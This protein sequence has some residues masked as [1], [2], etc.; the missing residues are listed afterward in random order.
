MTGSKSDPG[1]KKKKKR[2]GH[3]LY[4][5][6]VK[7]GCPV[8]TALHLTVSSLQ[9]APLTRRDVQSAYTDPSV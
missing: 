7:R 6:P 8:R 4:L 2:F 1:H 3:Q 9:G 5:W